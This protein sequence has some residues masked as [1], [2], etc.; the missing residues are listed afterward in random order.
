MK[1]C[2]YKLVSVSLE[3]NNFC[4]H[5]GQGAKL[6]DTPIIYSISVLPRFSAEF[7]DSSDT[8]ISG[9]TTHGLT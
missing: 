5:R 6:Q 9:I 4:P 3:R 1:T 8:H 2:V 7:L